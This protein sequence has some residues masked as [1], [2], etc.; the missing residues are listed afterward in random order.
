MALV[1]TSSFYPESEARHALAEPGE[2][3]GVTGPM[4]AIVVD[5]MNTDGSTGSLK[6]LA[7]INGHYLAVEVY[8]T[9]PGFFEKCLA[10]VRRREPRAQVHKVIHDPIIQ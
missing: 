2:A 10:R 8:I 3:E 7:E 1:E 6:G 4:I 9:A 5:N